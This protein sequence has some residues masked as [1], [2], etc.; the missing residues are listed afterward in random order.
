MTRALA[1]QARSEFY[2][3]RVD[4]AHANAQEALQLAV[5]LGQWNVG[6]FVPVSVL[7]HVAAIRGDEAACTAAVSRA[8]PDGEDRGIIHIGAA[9]SSLDLA[10][11][12]HEAVM[13]RLEALFDHPHRMDMLLQVPDMVEAAVRLG[14]PERAV[15][16][17][18]WFADYGMASGQVWAEATVARCRGLLAAESDAAQH[19]AH[20][21]KIHRGPGDRPFERARTQLLYG[22]WLRRARSPV[23]ARRQLRS[24]LEIFD[25]MGAAPWA[26]RTRRELRAAGESVADA[27][28]RPDVLRSLTSQERQVVRLAATGLTNRDIGAQLFL[29]PRTVGYH[30]YKAYPKLG[31]ASRGELARLTL[32]D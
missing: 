1:L 8:A 23:E 5:E 16:A 14:S 20:A 4:D 10:M 17:F 2:L 29:S 19:F 32:P 27:P 22:Q 24:A 26:Q 18:E 30:L 7:A 21:V 13:S 31:V 3:G 6:A 25:R 9:L 12:R 11:G 15:A 28:G